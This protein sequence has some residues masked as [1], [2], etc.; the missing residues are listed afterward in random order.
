[1]AYDR[2]IAICNPLLYSV[3]C[4]RRLCTQL[5][6]VPISVVGSV[7][8][9]KSACNIL[10]VFLCLPSHWSL[11]NS[12]Y[13]I[14]KISCSNLSVNRWYLLVWRLCIILPSIVVI[15][16]IL[17]VY[18]NHSLED[19]HSVKGE[20]SLLLH[21]QLPSGGGKSLL[22]GTVSFVYLTRPNNPELRKN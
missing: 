7:P 18:C 22:Y 3:I 6:A 14:E 13:Q 1:M 5:V 20:D 10:S 15:V 9:S 16:I 17:H 4:Q 8:S 19:P 2:F 11:H 21:L 12:S